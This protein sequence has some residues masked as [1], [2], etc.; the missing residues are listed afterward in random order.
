MQ[1]D[2]AFLTTRGELVDEESEGTIKILVLTELATNCIGYVVV[3]S[4]ARKVKR[5]GLQVVGP[6]RTSIFHKFSSVAHRCRKS[7][8]R[9]SRDKFREV[10][11]HG[12][13]CTPS[14]APIQWWS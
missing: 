1:A 8:F 6:L 2:F 13:S 3:T 9:I 5:S 7:G 10:H 4:D 14:T 12:A 11:I